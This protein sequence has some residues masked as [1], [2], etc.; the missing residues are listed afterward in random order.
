MAEQWMR[1]TEVESKYRIH[2][3]TLRTWARG[4]KIRHY[5]TDGGQFRYVERSV[6]EHLGLPPD[7]TDD[8]W[9]HTDQLPRYFRKQNVD[10]RP[11]A[12]RKREER[13]Q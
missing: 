4:G 9:F 5:R 2:P 12:V 10:R 7:D 13:G 1:P 8:Q 3:N 6:R 11:A